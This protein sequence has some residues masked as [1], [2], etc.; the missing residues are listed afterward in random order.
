MTATLVLGEAMV[1]ELE[2]A[3]IERVET[4]GVL[5]ASI[6]ES[7]PSTLRILAREIH[8]VPDSAYARRDSD[9]LLV[10]SAGYV[11]A[12]SRAEQIGAAAIWVHTHPGERS[13]PL[14]SDKDREVDAQLAEVF[15]V[16]SG[17]E[18]YGALIV[19]PG[20]DGFDFSGYLEGSGSRGVS[21]ER[22]W[23]VGSRLR[24]MVAHALPRVDLSPS[25]DRN[26]RA[27]GAAAQTVLGRLRVGV[28]G[29]G[30]TGSAI[31]E[32]L[33]RLG[34][35]QFTLVDPDN[36]SASNVTRV[37]GST[38]SDVGRPKVEALGD[39]LS[40]I[41]A[42]ISTERIRGSIVVE[43]VARR[44]LD[45]DVLFGCTD[46]NAGR[47]VLSRA[48]TY[49]MVPVIDCGVVLSSDATGHISGI[50]G[51]VTILTP[52]QACLVCRGRVDI[53]RAAAEL[54]Q[55]DERSRL[56]REGYAPG[57]GRVE[58]AV[59]AFTSAVAAAA[60]SEM[61]ERLVGYGPA[62]RPS[63]VIL[64][65]HEREISTNCANPRELHYC[66]PAAGKVGIGVTKPLLEQTWP[67]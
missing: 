7:A 28:V 33:A 26:I 32:Q 53:Q 59:V 49:F 29:C 43:R 46:D 63:E 67:Q 31:A 56:A 23:M 17:S 27:F 42:E 21:I 55:P 4:A 58:P 48:A 50:D 11:K 13:I 8:W 60:V 3:A 22:V 9:D 34:I 37:Y 61:L 18:Y 35:R 12:L 57:L 52:G 36:L 64:R 54:L 65:L 44:V 19:S 20:V 24:L 5:L 45:C 66:D 41:A 51:R 30:G 38:H 1:H 62:A 2:S 14:P 47:L 6:V 10:R 39:H 16:R 25:F 15:R 40:R